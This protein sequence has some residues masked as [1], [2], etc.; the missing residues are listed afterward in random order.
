[1]VKGGVLQQVVR[2][3]GGL[4]LILCMLRPVSSIDFSNISWD[5]NSYSAEVKEVN[6]EYDEQQKTVLYNSI[7]QRTAAYIEDK[8]KSLKMELRSTVFVGESEE[9]EPVLH[10]VTLYGP[11]DETLANWITQEL[12]IEK[13]QQEWR[14]AE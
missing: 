1:M 8:A 13:S 5:I 2:F 12:G 7:A 10:S 14:E 11:Y 6:E 9:G 4:F 3:T